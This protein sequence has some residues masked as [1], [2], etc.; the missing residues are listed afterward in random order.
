MAT[1]FENKV[2]GQRWHVSDAALIAKLTKSPDYEEIKEAV[3]EDKPQSK[4]RGAKA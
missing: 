3:K 1:W 4:K 2:T